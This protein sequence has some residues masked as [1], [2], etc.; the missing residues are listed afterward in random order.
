MVEKMTPD[1]W[2]ANTRV[3]MCKVPWDDAYRDIVVFDDV[4]EQEA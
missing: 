4:D 2:P 3:Q 1:Y